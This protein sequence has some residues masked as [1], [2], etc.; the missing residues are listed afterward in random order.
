[1]H[2]K[3]LCPDGLALLAKRAADEEKSEFLA[4]KD[5]WFRPVQF[6]NAPDG[7]LYIA[8]MYREVVEHPWSLPDAIKEQLDL[9]A[10]NDRGR[11]YRIVPEKFTRRKP[12]R[13]SKA[14]TAEL[15]GTLEHP[16]GWHRDTAARLLYERQDPSAIPLLEALLSNSRNPL[17]RL[18]ALCALTNA[19]VEKA[20]HD[21]DA[22][23]REHAVRRATTIEQIL[24]LA[25]DPS[26]QVRYQVAFRLGNFDSPKK[27]DALAAVIR[28]DPNDPWIRAAVMSSVKEE[29]L[30]LLPFGNP[31]FKKA[32][33]RQIGARK[34]AH[35]FEKASRLIN[36]MDISYALAL[37]EGRGA[38]SEASVVR[39]IKIAKDPQA[40]ERLAAIKV[41]SLSASPEGK[42][43]MLLSLIHPEE[44]ETIQR[45]AIAGLTDIAGSNIASRLVLAWPSLT[46][47]VRADALS[48]LLG[49]AERAVVLLDAIATGKVQ[50]SDLSSSQIKFIISHR[51]NDVRQLATQ[52][53]GK[54]TQAKR[55]DV[56]DQFSP[57]LSL[58]G[59]RAKGKQI[60]S[61][62]CASCH[63]LG[64]EG[65][66]LGPDL[67]TVKNAGKE[68][69]LL[70]IIDPNREVL[71]N[72]TSY[73][74]ES[75]WG[76]SYI[77]LLTE[78]GSEVLVR[79]AFGKETRIPRTKINRIVSQSQ[80]LMPEGLEAGLTPEG[81]ADLLEFLSTN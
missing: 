26:P 74:V 21:P 25:G 20:L 49:R 76:D 63:R 17:G 58:T 6:A 68:K 16:N 69:L 51:D 53:L 12:V 59:N 66:A 31:E 79:E 39:A 48:L 3:K 56:I 11:I 72:F 71:P 45:A 9:N 8:D 80:S 73:L 40:S 75:K 18:H 15:V 7:C 28:A 54:T 62:R 5:L 22:R 46:P 4:S 33:L 19:P 2:R 38:A 24:P 64:N 60:F 10:G 65:Y 50:R 30:A 47:A 52:V 29:A 35:E 14:S 67:V 37:A 77:G 57:A 44:T 13:L 36:D 42:R 78:S 23:V 1:M 34:D 55:Q 70:S 61:E 27:A 41:I 43:D 32:L 81:M